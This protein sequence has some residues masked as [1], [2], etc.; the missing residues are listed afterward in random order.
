MDQ[1][2][3]KMF[4][5]KVLLSYTSDPLAFSIFKPLI[6]L[7]DQLFWFADLFICPFSMI[8]KTIIPSKISFSTLQKVWL[9][10]YNWFLA[11][12]LCWRGWCKGW[13][14]TC[15]SL[16]EKDSG[17]RQEVGPTQQQLLSS[18]HWAGGE[19]DGLKDGQLLGWALSWG[20]DGKKNTHTLSSIVCYNNIHNHHTSQCISCA[21][22]K[23]G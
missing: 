7:I 15:A 17:H 21:S 11:Q 1:H 13:T 23:P 20:T 9:N 18:F 6:K 5:Y 8:F 16:H 22:P 3:N 19:T 2:N 14:R 10:L 4:L 12:W